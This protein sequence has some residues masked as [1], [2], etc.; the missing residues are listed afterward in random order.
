MTTLQKFPDRSFKCRMAARLPRRSKNGTPEER[1]AAKQ[2]ATGEV[3][4]MS[5]RTILAGAAALP[6]LAIP[7]I[8][9]ASPSIVNPDQHLV[10]LFAEL[11]IAAD[12]QA[13][14][15]QV[16]DRAHKKFRSMRPPVPLLSELPAEMAELW[17][18]LGVVD[19]DRM[20][21]AFPEH[22]LIVWYQGQKEKDKQDE[23]AREQLRARELEL[24]VECGLDDKNATADE[25]YDDK[26]EI[27][28][29]LIKVPAW[30]VAGLL[31]K[32][33]AG[34]LVH[35]ADEPDF[36]DSIRED[37]KRLAAS[38]QAHADATLAPQ[39]APYAHPDAELLALGQQMQAVHSEL[40][41]AYDEE[42]AIEERAEEKYSEMPRRR[43]ES[44]GL[45]ALWETLR[46]GEFER[47]PDEHPLKVW[48]RETR[49]ASDEAWQKW[50]VEAHRIAR[51]NGSD[52]AEAKSKRLHAALWEIGNDIFAHTDRTTQGVL[53]KM[54]A[55]AL[56]ALDEDF[57]EPLE[58]VWKS[59]ETLLR[60]RVG[61]SSADEVRS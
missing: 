54:R 13:A 4:P 8:A 26:M 21:K 14:A 47:L 1:E 37:I 57:E 53:V 15:D 6:T 20:E 59:I 50:T 12:N 36:I 23:P 17:Q 7:T 9:V 3:V 52:E 40:A 18:G 42:A 5:R 58:G 44:E 22:P 2:N 25:A 19:I 32:V 33:E 38:Q 41:Q 43:P 10:D 34:D 46:N 61:S 45:A 24:R 31:I 27:Y 56:L 39:I 30:T 55:V 16:N 35:L 29:E 11:K 28:D 60:N 49:E 51:E 48:E